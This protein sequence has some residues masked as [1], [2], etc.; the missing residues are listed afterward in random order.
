MAGYAK[1]I[2]DGS[3]SR[4]ERYRQ[5]QKYVKVHRKAGSEYYSYKHPKMDSPRSF[6]GDLDRANA[7]AIAVN[8][9]FA[10][11][12]NDVDDI[13]SSANQA[14]QQS[15]AEVIDRFIDEQIP[16]KNWSGNYAR[17]SSIRLQ[18]IRKL[19]GRQRFAALGMP[20]VRAIIY[21]HFHG[22]GIRQ[23]R[24]ILI[25]VWEFAISEGLSDRMLVNYPEKVALPAK[26]KRQ[27]PRIE[28]LKDFKAARSQCPPWLQDP[29]DIALITLQGRLEIVTAR[30][31]SLIKRDGGEYIRFQRQKTGYA[32]EIEVSG[33]LRSVIRRRQA[34]ALRLGCPFLINTT[35]RNTKNRVSKSR[36]HRCQ[37]LPEYLTRAWGEST[38][39]AF[40][41]IRSLGRRLYEENLTEEGYSRGQA[42]EYITALTGWSDDSMY[43]LY[44]ETKEVKFTSAKAE[45]NP[46]ALRTGQ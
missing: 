11:A 44:G 9:H 4:A 15:L 13:L 17:E 42:Q 43:K 16:Q 27:R 31:D 33:Y 26:T 25:H 3:G 32:V 14:P 41:E 35:Y 30:T 18:K 24:N 40:H 2:A 1:G 19:E 39:Y 12:K 6:G 10:N 29:A 22:D 8:A 7:C 45:L 38:G 21:D 20:E 37:V 46:G 5:L 28:T 36:Q 34:E 23:A